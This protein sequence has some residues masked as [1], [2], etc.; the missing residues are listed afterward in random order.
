MGPPGVRKMVPTPSGTAGDNPVAF[1]A[2]LLLGRPRSLSVPAA[3]LLFGP[4]HVLGGLLH[5]ARP[6]GNRIP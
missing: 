6:V 3:Q 5:R 2:C 4:P 1:P